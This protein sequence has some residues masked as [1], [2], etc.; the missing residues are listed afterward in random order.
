MELVGELSRATQPREVLRAFSRGMRALNGPVGYIS[1]S[2][3]D[4]PVGH[5]RIT[6]LLLDP[7]AEHIDVSDPWSMVDELTLHSG[8]LLGALIRSA[9]PAL[10]HDLDV[11][12]DP[13]LGKALRPFR[14]LM[15]IPLFDDGEPLNWAF[16]FSTEPKRFTEKELEETVLR[17][18]LIGGRVKGTVVANELQRANETIRREVERIADIQRGLLPQEMPAVPGV[19]LAAEYHTYD[20]AGGDYYD[21]Q[22]LTRSKDGRSHDPNGPWAFI[23]ADAAGH[24]PAAAVLMAML[25]A[26]LHAYPHTPGGPGEVLSHVSRHLAQKRLESSFVTAFFAIY[27]PKTREFTYARAGHPPPML[28]EPGSGGAVHRLDGNGGMPLGIFDDVTYEDASITLEPGQSIV[29][30]TDGIT[31]GRDHDGRMFGVEGVESSLTMCTGQPDCVQNS[32]MGALR[33]HEN[34]MRPGDDQTLL[35]MRINGTTP[36]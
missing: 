35:I 12:D 9:Y 4:L 15:A 5:Y 29:M 20:Q 17:S 31:E 26:I 27:D 24:G 22:P 7:D 10:V 25:H 34:G 16:M 36:A 8:G 28:K 33:E 1:L 11:Q 13:V 21:I 18:N 30:Y 3:R 19:T 32:I 14:S 6:R 23:V 2:T